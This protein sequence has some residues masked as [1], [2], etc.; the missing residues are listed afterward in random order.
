[1]PPKFS[2]L[3]KLIYE[4]NFKDVFTQFQFRML[5]DKARVE[6]LSSNESQICKVGQSFKEVIYIAQI[7]DGF[8]VELRDENERIISNVKEGSWIGIAEYAIRED[9][10]KNPVLNKAIT[11]GD[12]ELVWEVSASIVQNKANEN[13]KTP[14]RHIINSKKSK[15]LEEYVYLKKRSEG[16]IVYKFTIEVSF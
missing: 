15:N 4:R 5:L 11:Q 6:Y 9:Y 1:M 14:H 13:H 2:D 3:E 16:C 12:Y 10:L 8:S 7:N